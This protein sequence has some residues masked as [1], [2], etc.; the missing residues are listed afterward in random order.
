MAEENSGWRSL[1]E[2]MARARPAAAVV[3]AVLR[4]RPLE[5]V[6][7]R[8]IAF[9]TTAPA[10]VHQLQ[11]RHLHEVYG[12]EVV[13]VSGNLSRRDALRADVE[14]ARDVD[15]F[16]TEVKGA[17][18]DVVAEAASARGLDVVLAD[19]DLLPLPGGPNLDEEL[20]ALAAA[21]TQARL[22]A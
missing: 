2:A 3:A 16:V 21:A 8:R 19:N 6:A 7:G 11:A 1:A 14:L 10:P 4:P 15:A 17:A 22:A 18:I 13:L 9:F 12:A 5:T 20:R